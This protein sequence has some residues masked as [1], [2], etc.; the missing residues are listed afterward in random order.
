MI[1]WV[2]LFVKT[3]LEIKEG[4]KLVIKGKIQKKDTDRMF[5]SKS[6]SQG[7]IVSYYFMIESHKI[8]VTRKIYLRYVEGQTIEI[9][10]LP[11]SDFILKISNI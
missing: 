1:L 8:N 10:K 3:E 2:I 7:R 11:K 9:R 4:K 6:D 5:D